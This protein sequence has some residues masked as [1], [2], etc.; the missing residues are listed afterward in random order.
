MRV[1]HVAIIVSRHTYLQLL[2][3]NLIDHVFKHFIISTSVSPI[4]NTDP[5]RALM[6]DKTCAEE[7]EHRIN[8]S[9][10]CVVFLATKAA[11]EL[12]KIDWLPAEMD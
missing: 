10:R 2:I 11:V 3:V 12:P 7:P 8:D 9:G 4:M 1:I 5:R 6:H